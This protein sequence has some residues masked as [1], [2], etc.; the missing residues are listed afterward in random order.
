MT[1]DPEAPSPATELVPLL[2]LRN[3]VLFPAAVVPINVGRARS[4]KL[5]EDLSS[6]GTRLI[7][8]ITQRQPD[9]EDP[10]G[11]DLYAVGTLARVVKVIKLGTTNYS[12][13]L[14]GL[15]RF[16]LQ[17]VA[18]EVP[19]L[20]GNIV[21]HTEALTRSAEIEQLTLELRTTA[22][23]LA[24][25][26]PPVPR[27]VGTVAESAGDPGALA[28]LVAL[29][30]PAPQ[31]TPT[32]RQ[33]VLE[34][35]AIDE[36]LKLSNTLA[37]KVL[38]VHKVRKE[39]QTIVSG[40]MG[41]SEREDI[42]RAQ[43]KTIKEEL[44]ENDESEEELDQ[45]RERIAKA[46]LPVDVERAV[47]RQLGRLRAMQPHS[48]EYQVTRQ[49]VEW[50][51]DLPWSKMSEDKFDVE[52]VKRALDEDHYGLEKIKRRVVEYIAVRKIRRDKKGPIL[53][54]VGPPGTG[55]TSLAKSIARSVGRQ[56]VRISL[57]GVRD[58][59]EIRGHRRTYVGA[60][61]GRI[62]Q[63]MKKAK[64]LNPVLVLDEVD[65][66]GTDQRGDPAS[67]LLEVLDPE[68]N[69]SFVDHFIDQ[70][71]DLS[72]VMFVCTANDK[73]AIPAA[74][75][76][77]MEVIDIAGYTRTEKLHIA[78]DYLAPRS[79]SDHGLTPDR[80]EWSDSGYAA[81]IE[82]YTREAGVRSLTREIGAVCRAVA[83][84]LAAGEDVHEVGDEAFV[85]RVLGPPKFLRESAEREPTV[86]V[87][88]GLAY[89]PVG[90]D[91]LFIEASRMPGKGNPII[92]GSLGNVM[93]ESAATAMS[94]VR[95]RVKELGIDETIM[96]TSDLHVHVPKGGTPKDGPS[97]GIALVTAIV[98]RLT[99]RPV[100]ADLAMTGEVTLRGIVLPIGG[101][102]EKV[103]AAH[104][105][106]IKHVLLPT[107]NL[108]DLEEIPEEVR[109]ELTIDFVA[110]VGQVLEYALLPAIDVASPPASPSISGGADGDS[111]SPQSQ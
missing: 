93:K 41:R 96:A 85:Q 110:R 61:P 24:E 17:D 108:K 43:L 95:S 5:I 69:N 38:G 106:G 7:G 14:Q 15:C 37:R 66:M 27:E 63:A 75:L 92:T 52:A 50:I 79:L 101:V 70:P 29:H 20:K 44:G 11:A 53:C 19:Y 64:V 58:E 59:A 91:I 34:T 86:G 104:R 48:A 100:R 99:N 30:L 21:R 12:V 67:A 40:E 89:T 32:D 25:H 109:R 45:L 2:P 22:K 18:V 54:F 107:R 60:L 78:R 103:L 72:N 88:T 73:S 10:T 13:V 36:R 33:K 74:L 31:V 87:V 57:G 6:S 46:K 90:G 82:G 56:L 94:F 9:T 51:V 80:L 84:R 42:L 8:V 16:T 49:Y 105:A 111:D 83:V 71:Y 65:K 102:K 28:D 23:A 47:R 68:Q 3:A 77:R 26:S 62:I 55:K 76:D 4:V 35:F 97:A 98:S 39:I 1:N 81:L